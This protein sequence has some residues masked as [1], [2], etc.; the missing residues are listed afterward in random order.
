MDPFNLRWQD[1]HLLSRLSAFASE[2]GERLQR[3][4]EVACTAFKT[5][6]KH[7][8]TGSI[9]S[10]RLKLRRHALNPRVL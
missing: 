3:F 2:D 7:F 1:F 4:E 10:S 6:S 9:N 5:T 8:V